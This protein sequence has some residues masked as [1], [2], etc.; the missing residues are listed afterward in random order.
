MTAT[1]CAN[2]SLS[3]GVAFMWPVTN[4]MWVSDRG[5]GGETA[6]QSDRRPDDTFVDKRGSLG[7]VVRVYACMEHG[8]QALDNAGGKRSL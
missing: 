7:R 3:S 1:A 4:G 5:V 8:A 6:G 2:M